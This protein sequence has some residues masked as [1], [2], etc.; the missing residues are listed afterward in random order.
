MVHKHKCKS[1]KTIWEHERD[2]SVSEEEYN[3]RHNC[4]QC[5][6]NQR[7]VYFANSSEYKAH[8]EAMAEEDP[9]RY[10]IRLL[11][12]DAANAPDNWDDQY[13]WYNAKFPEDGAGIS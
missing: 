6:K 1:C 11:A 4:P 7:G 12:L 3:R 5:G 8:Y 13:E 9:V 10:L 2:G